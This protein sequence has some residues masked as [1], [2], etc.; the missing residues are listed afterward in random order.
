[1]A[2]AEGSDAVYELLRNAKILVTD[3]ISLEI[4]VSQDGNS[5][6]A[7]GDSIDIHL[8]EAGPNLKVYLPDKRDLQDHALKMCLP[9]RLLQWLMTDSRTQIRKETSEE[10]YNAALKIWIA[11]LS[12]LSKTLDRCRIGKIDTPDLD[13]YTEDNPSDT[14][15]H[16]GDGSEVVIT[17]PSALGTMRHVSP[18][19]YSESNS[20]ASFTPDGTEN[21]SN[22]LPVRLSARS[23]TAISLEELPTRDTHYVRVLERVIASAR[24]SAIPDRNENQPSTV[25]IGDSNICGSTQFERDCKVGAAGELFVSILPNG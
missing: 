1:M 23:R 24:T 17:P 20:S 4:S 21:E 3:T 18:G 19:T 15:P 9:E 5:Y 13:A 7:K 11:P 14:D 6:Q 22:G 25:H 2:T 10:A 16:E 12:T 8:D